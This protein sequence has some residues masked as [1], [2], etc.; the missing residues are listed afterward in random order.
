[1][2]TCENKVYENKVIDVTNSS[3]NEYKNCIF[4]SCSFED[5]SD[6]YTKKNIIHFSGCVFDDCFF[7]KCYVTISYSNLSNCF[8]RDVNIDKLD[9][10]NINN[11]KF[12]VHYGIK[13]IPCYT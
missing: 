3:I 6:I 11:L 4:K 1:M 7:E 13:H 5:S 2:E 12:L 8:F 10:C 9:C